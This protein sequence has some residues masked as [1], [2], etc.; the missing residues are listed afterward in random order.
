M[1]IRT[2]QRRLHDDGLTYEA[3]M[4]QLRLERAVDLLGTPVPLTEVSRRVGYDDQAHFTRAFKRWT[5]TTPGAWRK[6][7]MT[8]GSA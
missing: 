6:A 8:G 3:V 2:L 4:D 5:G 1:S 7:S